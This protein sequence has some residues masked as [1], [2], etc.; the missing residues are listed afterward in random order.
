MIRIYKQGWPIDVSVRR[1]AGVADLRRRS[2][3]IEG[4]RLQA[5]RHR[6]IPCAD[7]SR[8]ALY[9]LRA[10]RGDAFLSFR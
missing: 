4:A 8:T 1:I 9:H 7:V 3:A 6:G 10:P 2:A 5:T